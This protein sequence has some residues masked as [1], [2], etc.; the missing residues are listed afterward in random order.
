MTTPAPDLAAVLDLILDSVT[1]QD[2]SG[3]LV[4]A[5]TV[6]LQRLGFATLEEFAAADPTELARRFTVYDSHGSP[7]PWDHLPGRLVLRGQQSAEVLLRYRNELTGDEQWS[8]VH[9]APLVGADG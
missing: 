5:N 8:V 4:Y 3:R 1:I 7:F 6:A 2:A 9:A